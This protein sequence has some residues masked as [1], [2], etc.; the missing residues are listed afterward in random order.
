MRA[1]WAWMPVELQ[2][3]RRALFHDSPQGGRRPAGPGVRT[4]LTARPQ[5]PRPASP[6]SHLPVSGTGRHQ[7]RTPHTPQHTTSAR[8]FSCRHTVHTTSARRSSSWRKFFR[9]VPVLVPVRASPVPRVV[10][11]CGE[12]LFV[13][14]FYV[15]YGNLNCLRTAPIDRRRHHLGQISLLALLCDHHGLAVVTCISKLNFGS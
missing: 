4:H 13:A 14:R 1:L 15:F 8:L 10:R 11:D 5:A 3:V 9:G 6:T 2:L 7:V 12:I